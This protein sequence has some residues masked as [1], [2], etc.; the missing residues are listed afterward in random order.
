MFKSSDYSKEF[1][2]FRIHS[3][4]VGV[5]GLN[6]VREVSAHAFSSLIR[7]PNS[8][9]NSWT[10][11]KPVTVDFFLERENDQSFKVK[12]TCNLNVSNTCVR[13][14]ESVE[15][16]IQVNFKMRML[17]KQELFDR[18][19]EQ[20]E[21]SFDSNESDLDDEEIGYF[22]DKCIDLG[23]ILREQSFLELPDYPHCGDNGTVR[24]AP[25][26][27]LPEQEN[28]GNFKRENPFVKLLKKN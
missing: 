7:E 15:Y 8:H 6:F 3:H 17:E 14:L 9:V 27:L 4:E 5:N 2:Q 24:K 28:Q 20:D 23:L 16:V 22:R 1:A 26:K 21:L 12:G 18:D 11:L 13:C 25:C 19:Q 10:A